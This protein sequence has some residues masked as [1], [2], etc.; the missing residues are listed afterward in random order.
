[1]GLSV[2]TMA[3]AIAYITYEYC[4][5]SHLSSEDYEQAKQGLRTTRWFKGRTVW[6]QRVHDAI[7]RTLKQF[8]HK[9]SGGKISAERRSLVWDCRARN[10]IP[11]MATTLNQQGREQARDPEPSSLAHTEMGP[12]SGRHIQPPTPRDRRTDTAPSRRGQN[13]LRYPS[14][15]CAQI[16][17]DTITFCQP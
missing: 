8:L 7:I 6:V 4:T 17:R 16:S 14:R 11:P 12:V 1:M 3:A 9:L 13:P 2:T 5:Q 10:R 15:A